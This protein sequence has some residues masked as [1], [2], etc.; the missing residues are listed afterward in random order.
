M[1]LQEL[2][3][4]G[5]CIENAQLAHLQALT[6]LEWLVLHPNPCTNNPD[7]MYGYIL[8]LLTL[9]DED[10]EPLV[11]SVS[12]VKTL[13]WLERVD[14]VVVDQELRERSQDAKERVDLSSGSTLYSLSSRS[15]DGVWCF[16]LTWPI[17]AGI[18]MRV[19]CRYSSR[20]SRD[21]VGAST[22]IS[23]STEP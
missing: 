7:Y 14:A 1:G 10:D 16:A 21:C 18:T 20:Y 22:T 23:S 13:P 4:N 15:T 5:N 6:K 2:W 9:H 12:V 19:D 17:F 11:V 8:K 3:V